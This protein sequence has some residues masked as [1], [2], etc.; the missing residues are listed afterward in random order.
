MKSG[1]FI[2]RK[3]SVRIQSILQVTLRIA[4]ELHC[5]RC[6]LLAGREK[7]LETHRAASTQ[8]SRQPTPIYPPMDYAGTTQASTTN[9]TSVAQV[10]TVNNP[11]PLALRFRPRRRNAVHCS[12]CPEYHTS[13]TTASTKYPSRYQTKSK[14]PRTPSCGS[15][16][17]ASSVHDVEIASVVPW[18]PPEYREGN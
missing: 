13:T 8:Q 5:R 11:P 6:P 9:H 10:S 18:T 17:A 15:G 16:S 7:D 14:L 4:I 3:H 12:L 2:A 1:P